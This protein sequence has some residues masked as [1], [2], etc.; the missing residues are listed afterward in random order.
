MLVKHCPH[1][2]KK[3]LRSGTTRIICPFFPT[4]SFIFF[5]AW[6][7]PARLLGRSDHSDRARPTEGSLAL[8]QKT[9]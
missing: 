1:N 5:L 7:K 9:K 6:E 2:Q 8:G 4:N 3:R